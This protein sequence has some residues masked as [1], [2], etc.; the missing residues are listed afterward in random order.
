ML[1]PLS[2]SLEG[3]QQ[4]PSPTLSR[5]LSQT[6]RPVWPRLLSSYFFCPVSRFTYDF[7]RILKGRSL[8]FLQPPG[9]TE[10]PLAFKVKCSGGSSSSS[11]P[12]EVNVR[13]RPL[14]PVGEPLRCNYSPACGPPRWGCGTWLHRESAPLLSLRFLLIVFSSRISSLLGS[15]FFINGGFADSCDFSVNVRRGGLRVFLLCHLSQFPLDVTWPD[16]QC[17][18]EHA[19]KV[20]V[21]L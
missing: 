14:T 7:V 5:R 19:S 2:V 16:T 18:A 12:P 21:A 20:G 17:L 4:L 15:A 11:G 10:G 1:P 9:T 6:S 13:F 3:E 8:Y